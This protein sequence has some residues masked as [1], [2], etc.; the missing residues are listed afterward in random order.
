MKIIALQDK[1]D[2]L[3]KNTETSFTKKKCI[4]KDRAIC[5]CVAVKLQQESRLISTIDALFPCLAPAVV[6]LL[7]KTKMMK[8]APSDTQP[9]PCSSAVY[10]ISKL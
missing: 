5:A 4:G 7:T 9:A 3:H 2:K 1:R 6:A 10:S 8:N